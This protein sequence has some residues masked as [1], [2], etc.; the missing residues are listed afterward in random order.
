MKFSMAVPPVL[1]NELAPLQDL[2]Y[3]LAHLQEIEGYASWYAERRTKGEEVI[4]DNGFHETGHPLS[5]IELVSACRTF[6][7]TYVIAPDWFGQAKKTYEAYREMLKH[8]PS[9]V[10]I[11][12]VLQ[13]KNSTERLEFFEAVRPTCSMLCLPFRADRLTWFKE[14][15]ARVPRHISWPGRLHLLGASDAAELRGWQMILDEFPQI[16]K[17]LSLDTTKPIKY[18][19]ALQKMDEV[20][21]WR[22]L[23]GWPHEPGPKEYTFQ[24]LSLIRHNVAYIRRFL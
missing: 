6:N 8:R 1:L 13:G 16:H 14:L 7:P 3:A 18:G 11:A 4:L 17:H 5:A 23:G 2:H 24:Q 12:V 22:G 9:G 15:V 20:Q 21:K 19:L 10:R